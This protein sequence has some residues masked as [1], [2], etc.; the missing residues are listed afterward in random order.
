[1][2]IQKLKAALKEAEA[3]KTKTATFHYLM[4][5]HA[6]ELI[7]HDPKIL[8]KALGMKESMA[9]E[10]RKMRALHLLMVS[11]NLKI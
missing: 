3:S 2:D 7:G 4:L 10:V 1:M 5:R 6:D 11:R 8:C 9:S